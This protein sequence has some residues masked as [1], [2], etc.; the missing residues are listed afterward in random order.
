MI[1]QSLIMSTSVTLSEFTSTDISHNPEKWH[2]N[3]FIVT[4]ITSKETKC[5]FE[6]KLKS[7]LQKALYCFVVSFPQALFIC[8]CVLLL[9]YLLLSCDIQLDWRSIYWEQQWYPVLLFM[10]SSASCTQWSHMT[11]F[12]GSFSVFFIQHIFI[13]LLLWVRHCSI[14]WGVSSV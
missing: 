2:A 5:S 12:L 13:E 7:H 8:C 1:P 14:L 10:S 9:S 3:I 11:N 6:T 4:H